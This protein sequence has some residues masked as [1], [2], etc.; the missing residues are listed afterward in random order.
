[1]D[2]DLDHS[3]TA[4][5]GESITYTATADESLS[6]AVIAALRT[7]ASCS[8]N[9]PVGVLDPLFE[10]IDPEALD[11]LFSDESPV[12]SARVSFTHDGFDVQVSATGRVTVVPAIPAQTTESSTHDFSRGLP[13]RF[14]VS[15]RPVRLESVATQ[16][17]PRGL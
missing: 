1:M 7:A 17:S 5:H 9:P 16:Q 2:P 15:H 13:P 6:D 14:C 10:T 3:G 8:A 12:A 4:P 11:T